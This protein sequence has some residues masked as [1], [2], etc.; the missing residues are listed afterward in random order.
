MNRLL[1]LLALVAV[2]LSAPA[3]AQAYPSDANILISRPS[4]LATLPAGNV[5]HAT[6]GRFAASDDGCRIAFASQADGLSSADDNRYSNVFVRDVCS[7]TTT[8]VSRASGSGGAAGDGKSEMPTISGDGT[9]VAFVSEATNLGG[10][11]DGEGNQVYVRDLD[12][13]TTVL[14]SVSP[15]GAS[16][17]SSVSWSPALDQDG[18]TVAF[19]SWATN[20]VEGQTGSKRQ[21]FVRRLSG[22]P[23]TTLVSRADTAAG[24]LGDGDSASPSLND[25][26][27]K[28]AFDSAATNLVAGDAGGRH[29]VFVRDLATHTNKLVSRA[30]GADGAQG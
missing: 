10:P 6:P 11:D 18:D 5:N 22:T 25:A 23:V 28:V 7:G 19:D 1:P 13:Q 9:V 21:V 2:A 15:D 8:L 3:A 16:A 24:A 30:S 26:G 4:G 17:G 27:T 20:L 14:A 12:A 29:D